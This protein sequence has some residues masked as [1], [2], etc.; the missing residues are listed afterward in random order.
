MSVWSVCRDTNTSNWQVFGELPTNAT[1]L[2]HYGFVNLKTRKAEGVWQL[3]P[4]VFDWSK[5]GNDD[6]LSDLLPSD[7]EYDYRVNGY[8]HIARALQMSGRDPH[9]VGDTY[10]DATRY[11]KTGELLEITFQPVFVEGEPDGSNHPAKRK[12][13]ENDM[14]DRE[15][16]LQRILNPTSFIGGVGPN[17]AS[18]EKHLQQAREEMEQSNASGNSRMFGL[19]GVGASISGS[20]IGGRKRPFSQVFGGSGLETDYVHA[21]IHAT[22]VTDVHHPNYGLHSEGL[23]SPGDKQ[24]SGATEKSFSQIDAS[25]I[26]AS[27]ID[28]AQ[29]DVAQTAHVGQTMTLAQEENAPSMANEAGISSAPNYSSQGNAQN[30]SD[31]AKK[32]GKTTHSALKTQSAT[33]NGGMPSLMGTILS[34]SDATSSIERLDTLPSSGSGDASAISAKSTGSHSSSNFRASLLSMHETN[35]KETRP[36]TKTGGSAGK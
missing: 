27:Q 35:T 5:D 17:G 31:K 32:K 28:V 34:H 10:S 20:S 2:E 16:Q 9:E 4:F 36:D 29:T 26:D 21:S 1:S 18:W 23:I 7:G 11:R 25:Q 30:S 6:W 15:L 14:R 19:F 13:I 24:G 33:G 3:V 22:N 12:T 8:W